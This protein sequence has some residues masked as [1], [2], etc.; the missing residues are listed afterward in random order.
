[1]KVLVDLTK[2]KFEHS[3]VSFYDSKTIFFDAAT[4]LPPTVSFK[5]W[6]AGL[7]PDFD[8]T[9][10]VDI[11]KEVKIKSI[12]EKT[13][14]N[15]TAIQGFGT[16]TFKN[17]VAGKI[18]IS[19][20]DSGEFLKDKHGN[21]VEFKRE[22][23]L[24]NID[25]ECFEYCLDTSIYFPYG[26]CDLKLYAKGNV[27]FEFDS[28]N[29]VN[30]LDYITN[31]NRRETFWGYFKDESLTTNSYNYEDL[32]RKDERTAYNRTL[33]KAG[34]SWWQKLFGSE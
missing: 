2:Q 31:P 17:V 4:F 15:E 20:Y 24:E 34:R 11:S 3:T 10:Y 27:T 19:P 21:Q 32:D 13:P 25:N 6:G 26:A 12:R 23:T 30:Y 5:V 16:L 18:S 29:C 8:W 9:K 33:P 14:G 7:M 22:W 28:D 1:M